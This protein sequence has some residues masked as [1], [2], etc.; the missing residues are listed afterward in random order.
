MCELLGRLSG[1]EPLQGPQRLSWVRCQMME[2][3]PASQE[4]IL[5]PKVTVIPRGRAELYSLL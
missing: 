4:A 3:E 1:R 5:L 2:N